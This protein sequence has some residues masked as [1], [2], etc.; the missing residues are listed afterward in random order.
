MDAYKKAG[1]YD[2]TIWVITADHGMAP[3][4]HNISQQEVNAA[5]AKS[6]TKCQIP[7]PETLLYD[8]SKAAEAV[9]NVVTAGIPGIKGAYYHF[10]QADGTWTY[11]PT[12]TTEKLITGDL[13]KCFRYLESTHCCEASA[14]FTLIEKENWRQ[15][16]S[17]LGS[18][19]QI[20][21]HETI[22]WNDQ[23]I[24]LIIAGPGVKQGVNLG[25]PARL[26]DIA[27]TVLSLAGIR[28]EKMDGIELADCMQSPSPQQVKEQSVTSGYLKPLADALKASSLQDL[29][30]NER[31]FGTKE[32]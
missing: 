6:G 31:E 26:V 21:S 9:E 16:W 2:R 4:L 12:P 19:P 22:T 3:R 11:L 23:H 17:L 18:K 25:S 27:P 8:A 10:K 28:P 15:D 24:P 7:N 32:Q 13:D 20:S 1:I 30:D 29:A 14:D 5:I